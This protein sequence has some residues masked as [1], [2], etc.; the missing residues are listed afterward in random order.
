[1]K[2]LAWL[3]VCHSCMQRPEEHE[4]LRASA[5]HTDGCDL[6]AGPHDWVVVLLTSSLQATSVWGTKVEEGNT[7]DCSCFPNTSF[8]RQHTCTAL[9]YCMLMFVH[10]VFQHFNPDKRGLGAGVSRVNLILKCDP[11]QDHYQGTLLLPVR[12]PTPFRCTHSENHL[13]NTDHDNCP[14]SSSFFCLTVS[15]CVILN[16]CFINHLQLFNILN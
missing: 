16:S 9:M 4:L 6:N 1:M 10:V 2:W 7:R 3:C 8:S 14:F 11:W 13:A 12:T 15:L 5:P